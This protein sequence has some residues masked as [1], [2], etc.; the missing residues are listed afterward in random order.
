MGL[1]GLFA[2]LYRD[3]RA[4]GTNLNAHRPT[5]ERDPLGGR[6]GVLEAG[7]AGAGVGAAGVEHDRREPA[8]REHLFQRARVTHRRSLDAVDFKA[9]GRDKVG[10]TAVDILAS[11]LYHNELGLPQRP[12]YSMIEGYWVAGR[13][14]PPRTRKS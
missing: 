6:V 13:T 12:V 14:A 8:R 7:R 11:Q 10:A 1:V 3:K 2:Y 5:L 4:Q 9:G